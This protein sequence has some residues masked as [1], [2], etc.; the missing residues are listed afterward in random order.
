MILWTKVFRTELLSLE[1]RVDRI[2]FRLPSSTIPRRATEYISLFNEAS[3]ISMNW[4][5][6]ARPVSSS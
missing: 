5:R 1:P 4:K 6:L 3:T 2:I